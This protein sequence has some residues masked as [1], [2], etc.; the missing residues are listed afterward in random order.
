MVAGYPINKNI[1]L[2][3]ALRIIDTKDR[4]K[5]YSMSPETIQMPDHFSR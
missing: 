2:R 3:I 5:I 4:G 1:A